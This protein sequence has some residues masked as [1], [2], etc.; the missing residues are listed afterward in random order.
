[1]K[2]FFSILI[3]TRN[4]AS[5]LKDALDSLVAQ[6]FGDFEVVINDNSSD[7]ETTALVRTFSDARIRYAKAPRF[8]LT[9]E[10]WNV[11][12]DRAEGE[13]ILVLGDDDL[14][15]PGTLSQVAAVI[16][17]KNAKVL[18]Y[19]IITYFDATYFEARL[20]NTIHVRSFSGAIVRH[21]AGKVISDYFSFR[22][23]LGYPPH[24]SA[25]IY[26]KATADGLREKCGSFYQTPLGE[27]IAMPWLLRRTGAMY[28]IDKPLAV[29]SRGSSSQVAQEIHEPE[30][31]WKHLDS[32]FARTPCK[33]KYMYNALA[34]S[35]LRLQ[36]LEPES[37]GRY[38]LPMDEYF[39][40][41]YQDMMEVAR[42]GSDVR[43]DM[44]EFWS[45]FAR[46]PSAE[47]RSAQRRLFKIKLKFRA[48]SLLLKLGLFE[49]FR[50][51]IPHH[52]AV[53]VRASEL[54][55]SSAP[56]CAAGMVAIGAKLGQ[57]AAIWDSRVEP[58]NG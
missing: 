18:S 39:L 5:L 38:R 37:F 49:L 51:Y 47:R 16:K 40:L 52:G 9:H 22:S 54:G 2:P 41:Y 7:D 8:L 43:R 27:I 33:G 10:N 15:L 50:H 34:E 31:M 57:P 14:L 17:K 53:H 35:L 56:G 45:E 11:C 23:G 32:D 20:R 36:A 30:K 44:E 1:L 42:G 55:V 26:H 3:P 58:S 12:Y 46:L 24:P 13:Y 6:D 48:R 21:D 4:R 25:M 29:I 19:G 28:V